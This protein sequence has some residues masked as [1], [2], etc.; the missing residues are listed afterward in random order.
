MVMYEGFGERL[1]EF[2]KSEFKNVNG[3]ISATGIPQAQ[4]SRYINEKE[5]PGKKIFEKLL[6]AG[7]DINWLLGG[8][9]YKKQDDTGMSMTINNSNNEVVE[10]PDNKIYKDQIELLKENNKLL[11]EK[12]E[13]LEQK[14]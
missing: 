6:A 13:R 9:E 12:I 2:A 11:Q 1:R 8:G 3:L 4:M 10:Q 7:C 5:E 14:S